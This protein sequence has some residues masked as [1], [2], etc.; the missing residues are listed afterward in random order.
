MTN[1]VP[2]PMVRVLDDLIQGRWVLTLEPTPNGGT[3]V[4]AYRP[5]GWTGPGDPHERLA[6]PDHAAMRDLLARH[7]TTETATEQDMGEKHRCTDPAADPIPDDLTPEERAAVI[8]QGEVIVDQR[9]AGAPLI[10]EQR[11]RYAHGD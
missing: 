6:A 10:G 4:V 8:R 2:D 1:D 9:A 7:H 11:R 5:I 3:E